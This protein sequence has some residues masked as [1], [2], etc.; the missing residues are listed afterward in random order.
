MTELYSKVKEKLKDFTESAPDA[1]WTL[2]GGILD[3]FS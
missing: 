2:I 1:V 3:I